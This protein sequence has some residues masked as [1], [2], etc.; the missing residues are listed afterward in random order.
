MYDCLDTEAGVQHGSL[1]PPPPDSP[2]MLIS[3]NQQGARSLAISTPDGRVTST[4]FWVPP[5]GVLQI[6]GMCCL[7][8]TVINWGSGACYQGSARVPA[9]VPPGYITVVGNGPCCGT[10]PIPTSSGTDGG[11]PSGG[12][13]TKRLVSMGFSPEHNRTDSTVTLRDLPRF[14]QNVPQYCR[15]FVYPSGSISKN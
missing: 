9:P 11:P 2:G 14:H 7:R 4:M 1:T 3:S 13:S 6:G 10:H 5:H 15:A 8:S 12:N